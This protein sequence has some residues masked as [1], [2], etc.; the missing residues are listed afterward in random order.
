MVIGLGFGWTKKEESVF[1]SKQNMGL[2][3]LSPEKSNG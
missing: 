2:D 1:F 3:F